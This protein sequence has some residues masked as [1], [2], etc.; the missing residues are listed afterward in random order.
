MN[1]ADEEDRVDVDDISPLAWRLL[2]TAAG[3]EQ[4]EVE[5]QID[6]IMQAHIS[7]LENETRSL[8]RERLWRLFDLYA[9]ELTQEQINAIVTN[10]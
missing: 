1:S 2:R 5:R 4:R 9:V 3:Y 10:F 7:M 8:S 6:D